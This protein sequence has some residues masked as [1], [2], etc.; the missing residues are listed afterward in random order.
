LTAFLAAS[1]ASTIT[2]DALIGWNVDCGRLL[3]A[4]GIGLL[5]CLGSGQPRFRKLLGWPLTL[6]VERSVFSRS[7]VARWAVYLLR[8][9]Y[10][11]ALTVEGVAGQKVDFARRRIPL[12]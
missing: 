3:E 4:L 10:Q 12:R 5:L 6:L 8:D 11:I 1:R 2:A 7:F 9:L